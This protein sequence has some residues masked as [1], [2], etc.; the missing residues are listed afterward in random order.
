MCEDTDQKWDKLLPKIEYVFN[1][2][3]N[4][5]IDG[6]PSELLFGMLQNNLDIEKHNIESYIHNNQLQTERDNLEELRNKAHAKNLEVQ[7][8]NQNLANRKRIKCPD[9]KEG[10]FVVLKSVDSHKLSQKF[11]GPYQI[12]KIL[13]NDRFVVSDIEGFQ[14]SSMP[15]NS[16]CSPQNMRK[17][18]HTNDLNYDS[19]DED[20]AVVRMSE[21]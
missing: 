1:N 2:T 7:Q 13:P 3:Y 16:V 4:R 14:I 11:K 21:M 10:D 17:W 19:I 15:F 18:V 8:Y 9:Y 12:K 6:Y 5:S 20:I